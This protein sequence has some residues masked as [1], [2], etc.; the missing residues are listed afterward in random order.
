[1]SV[2]YYYAHVFLHFSVHIL[3]RGWNGYGDEK[4]PARIYL[5]NRGTPENTSSQDLPSKTADISLPKERTRAVIIDSSYAL[6]YQKPAA[7]RR[8]TFSTKHFA[9]I[10]DVFPAN[11]GRIF[12]D[13]LQIKQLTDFLMT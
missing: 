3:Q 12:P 4:P 7:F 1:M 11:T 10:T 9:S 13:V 2:K 5:R 8:R 6:K